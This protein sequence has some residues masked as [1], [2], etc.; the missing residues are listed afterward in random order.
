MFPKNIKVYQFNIKYLVC[1][2]CSQSE[3]FCKSFLHFYLHFTQCL[4]CFGN[5]FMQQ[6]GT[7]LKEIIL[8]SNMMGVHDLMGKFNLEK[9]I[10][11]SFCQLKVQLFFGYSSNQKKLKFN[12]NVVQSFVSKWVSC[13]HCSQVKMALLFIWNFYFS[14]I[15]TRLHSSFQETF[16]VTSMFI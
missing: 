6:L 4:H 10:S 12:A 7:D 2:L 13:C 8:C 9:K 3:G 1:V 14:I 15:K 16:I 5:E 11:E